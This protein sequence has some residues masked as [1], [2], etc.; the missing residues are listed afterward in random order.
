[1]KPIVISLLILL[2]AALYAQWQLFPYVAPVE[3]S[4][5]APVS[6]GGGVEMRKNA[7]LAEYPP[8]AHFEE[9]LQRPLFYQSRRPLPKAEAPVVKQDLGRE[10]L[11]GLLL[12]AIIITPK[13]TVALMKDQKSGETLRLAQDGDFR[14]WKVVRVAEGEVRLSKNDMVESMKLRDYCK[15]VVQQKRP[16]KQAGR[17]VERV[18]KTRRRLPAARG[19]DAQQTNERRRRQ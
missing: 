10:A 15:P 9:V 4:L 8:E 5:P 17:R 11:Q 6:E 18:R 16:A 2:A 1:M 14:G 19:D 3:E 13:G 12:S 7:A